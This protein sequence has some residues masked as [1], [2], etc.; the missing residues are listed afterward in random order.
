M[1][2]R[3]LD[4]LFIEEGLAVAVTRFQMLE[5]IDLQNNWFDFYVKG[6]LYPRDMLVKSLVLDMYSMI[7]GDEFD[8]EKR[9]WC[10]ITEVNISARLLS[11]Y[12]MKYDSYSVSNSIAYFG[13][14]DTPNKD[15]YGYLR[16]Y[17][18]SASFAFFMLEKGSRDDYL[19]F[20]S[21]ISLAEKIY[22]KDLNDLIDEWMDE[23]LDMAFWYEYLYDLITEDLRRS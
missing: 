21:D 19:E 3:Q 1:G 11:A 22:G 5:D 6:I 12:F 4:T 17:E 7:A 14:I 2:L 13:T 20:L 9:E 18:T 8:I 16:S 10:A 15:D 23:Y